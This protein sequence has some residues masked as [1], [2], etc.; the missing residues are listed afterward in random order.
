LLE[1]YAVRDELDDLKERQSEIVLA[2]R[3]MGADI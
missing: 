1:F 3:L 2:L